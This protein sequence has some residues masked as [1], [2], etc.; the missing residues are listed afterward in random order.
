MKKFLPLLI[1]L[2]LCAGC[3][4]DRNEPA[5]WNPEKALGQR[6]RNAPQIARAAVTNELHDAANAAANVAATVESLP[7]ATPATEPEAVATKDFAT[8]PPTPAELPVSAPAEF[9]RVSKPL[10]IDDEP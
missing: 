6:N 9:R 1:V 10:L 3:R 8:T 7:H 5:N 2:A 4:R